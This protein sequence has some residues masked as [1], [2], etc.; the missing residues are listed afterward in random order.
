MELP[1]STESV[2][3]MCAAHINPLWAKWFK[4]LYVHEYLVKCGY[5]Y[6]AATVIVTIM[7]SALFFMNLELGNPEFA[8]YLLPMLFCIHFLNMARWLNSC[9]KSVTY[10]LISCGKAVSRSLD[11]I[12]SWVNGAEFEPIEFNSPHTKYMF[13][14]MPKFAKNYV[15]NKSYYAMAVFLKRLLP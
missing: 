4:S 14:I 5:F 12:R 2:Q 9:S 8:L 1:R 11:N 3:H 13:D 15:E 6:L 7:S 10:E